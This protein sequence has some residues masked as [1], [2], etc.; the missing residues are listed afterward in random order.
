MKV[1]LSWLHSSCTLAAPA[2]TLPHNIHFLRLFLGV[3][4]SPRAFTLHLA[5]CFA[6]GL[7][8]FV[9][10]VMLRATCFCGA[11]M[12]LSRWTH[13][14]LG[15]P[16]LSSTFPCLPWGTSQPLGEPVTLDVRSIVYSIR[17]TGMG[18][19]SMSYLVS[20]LVLPSTWP[21][22]T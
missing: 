12:I 19:T 13:F 14:F 5:N 3:L 18:G 15:F 1:T 2:S 4:L 17:P 6:P 8:H 10:R 16:L 9:S 21:S 11:R 22:S 7:H 20:S